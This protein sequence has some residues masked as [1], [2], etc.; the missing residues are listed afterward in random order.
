MGD[1]GREEF[2]LI[3]IAGLCAGDELILWITGKSSLNGFGSGA[4]LACMKILL[5]I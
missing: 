5:K 1:G 4:D 2:E 3:A